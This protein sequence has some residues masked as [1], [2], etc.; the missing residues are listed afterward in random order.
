MNHSPVH[1]LPMWKKLIY[2]LGQLG[3]SL[4]SFGVMNLLNFFYL[5]NTNKNGKTIFPL[6]ITLAAILGI[7]GSISRLFDAFTDPLI[8][9]WSDRSESKLGRRMKFLAIGGLPFALLSF[10]VFFPPVN[11]I[12]IINIIWLFITIVLFYFF[13]TIYVT[14]YFALLS[15]L[16]H[17]P[18]ERLQ[19][20]TIISFFW[21][22]GFLIGNT[23]YV[24]QGKLEKY[25]SSVHA[26]QI[27]LLIFATISLI[28]MYL[29]VFL[30][31]E[32]KYCEAHTSKEGSFEALI[33]AFKNKNFRFFA[34]S[35]L[36][37]W[38][39]LTFIQT[40]IS[41]YVITLLDLNKEMSTLFMGIAFI[42]SLVLYLPTGFIAAKIGK[43]RLL[44][45][46][47]IIF[48]FVFI[49]VSTFGL[50]SISNYI[51]GVI[52]MLLSAAPLAV[53]GIIP[54]AIVADIAD[55]DGIESGNYKAAIFFGARTFMSK[56]GASLTLLL[57]PII[58]Q[59][60]S[61]SKN[62]VTELGVRMASMIAIIFALAGLFLLQG[63]SEKDILKSLAKKEQLSE[64]E[65]N[66]IKN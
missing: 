56:V 42:G 65:L 34:L 62:E 33:N 8:A 30:I 25:F 11:G 6:F 63:Y 64:H 59:V 5:P 1:K 41:Y 15:E 27:T 7:I 38:F 23:V 9:G 47:F 48:V 61:G 20:S 24:I 26:L 19:L 14:P 35:D 46:A 13:M 43:K 53:F 52:V 44:S 37:Y 17:S 57:F 49:G 40:G 3:W 32:K 60:G 51:N 4:A 50:L 2:A 16:G 12:S 21:A 18:D 58:V 45:F 31:D 36:T 55:A 28:C 22:I 10:L 39:S 29:P 54:N 66:E